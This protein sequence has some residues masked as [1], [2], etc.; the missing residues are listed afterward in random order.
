MGAATVVPSIASW[1]AI[2]SSIIAASSTV[3]VIGATW[4]KVQLTGITPRRL[5]L[6]YVGFNPTVPQ[7]VDGILPDPPVS[8]PREPKEMHD[9]TEAAEP[10]LE[11][12]VISSVFQ[13]FLQG[14][15]CD[16][17]LVGP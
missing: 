4:S 1:P 5:T 2:A 14:P 15:M 11:P 8:V 13:G 9:A 12:P 3:L 17:S 7:K 10:P 6:P 16:S